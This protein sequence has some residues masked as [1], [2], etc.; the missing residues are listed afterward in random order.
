M[1]VKILNE[2]VVERAKARGI[3]VLVYAPH[4]TRL[5]DIGERAAQFSD[6]ELLVVPAREVFTGSWQNRRHLLAV[7][8]TNPIPDF[9][10]LDGAFAEF[11]RQGAA[12]L[13]PH[14]ELLNVSMEREDLAAARDVVDA[15]EVYNAKC[16]P[17]QNRR[18]QHIAADLDI[19]AYGSSYAHLRRTIGEAWTEFDRPIEGSADLV[20]ALKSGT[21]RRVLHRPGLSHRV[22]SL[23]EFSHLGF[24]N[25]WGKIDRL[26]LSGMEPTHPHHVA[27]EGRF[28][29]VAVY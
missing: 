8:L 23:V 13:A 24:E 4:F 12:V 20:D 3:D 10:T 17:P 7:G 6:E 14:P 15:I 28:D 26:L 22:A 29:D 21:D 16:Q 27:Y 25:S 19:P 1:H 18:G 11:E 2:E 9:I 5:P